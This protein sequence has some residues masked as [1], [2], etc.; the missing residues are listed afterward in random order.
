MDRLLNAD[1][2]RLH[3]VV[4][5]V[6]EDHPSWLSQPEASFAIYGERGAIDILAFHAPSASLLVIELKTVIA[7]VQDVV[8]GLDRKARLASRVAHERGWSTRSISVWLAV[9]ETRTNRRRLA[10]HRAM[11]RAAFPD[12][13]RRLRSWLGSPVGVVRALS[14]LPLANPG[15]VSQ[16]RAGRKRV[17]R[18]A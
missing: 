4:A 5:G 3:E 12:D 1:H 2:S 7:D 17:R 9:S 16:F 13:G 8:G 14:F 6:L 11:L 15:S 10:E 18:A